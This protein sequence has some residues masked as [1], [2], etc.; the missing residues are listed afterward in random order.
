MPQFILF[1]LGVSDL[2]VYTALLIDVSLCHVKKAIAKLTTK[3][4]EE[5]EEYLE[6]LWVSEGKSLYKV[7]AGAIAQACMGIE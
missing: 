4:R 5:F 3:E 2:P 1:I 6:L 7:V